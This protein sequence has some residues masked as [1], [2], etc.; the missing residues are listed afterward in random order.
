VT[1]EIAVPRVVSFIVLLA[2]LLLMGAMFFQVMAKFVVPLFLAAVLVVMF[3]PLHMWIRHKIPGYPR[4]SALATTLAILLAILLPTAYLAWN[5]YHE[6]SG[7]IAYLKAPVDQV[8]TADDLTSREESAEPLTNQDETVE[9]LAIQEEAVAQRTHQDEMTEQL[10]KRAHVLVDFYTKITGQPLDLDALIEEGKR[11]IASTLVN[12][13][14]TAGW[15]LVGTAIMVL[16]LYYFFLDGPNMIAGIMKMSPLDDEYERELLDKFATISRAVVVASLASAAAQGLLAGV[17]YYFAL[18]A[19]APIFLLTMVT[20][21]LALVPFVGAAAV[22]IPTVLWIYTFQTV[23]VNGVMV[24]GDTFSAIA[25][26]I[27]GVCVISAIDNVIKPL[28]LH[29][30]SNLHPLLALLSIL[31][32]VQVLGPIGILVGPMLVA[33]FQALLNMVNKELYR[34]GGDTLG[35]KQGARV[36][37]PAAASAGGAAVP[38][39]PAEQRSPSPAPARQPP[40]KKRRK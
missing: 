19:G 28:V 7:V 31:G 22:W 38:A 40:S 35:A 14:K 16:A 25:L 12:N 15:T 26:A 18:N 5:A 23:E 10:R 11:Q 33:F 9:Q 17:G 3:R 8:A 2:I 36:A 29:G 34:L 39:P 21:V 4:V 37:L 24:E 20:M 30:Q 32:G 6:S 1:K 13:A 27:Y